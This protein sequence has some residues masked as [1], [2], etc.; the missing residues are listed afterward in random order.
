M[1]KR[2][3]LGAEGFRN[4]FY[5]G[6]TFGL[7]N[8]III[9]VLFWVVFNFVLNRTRFGRHVYAVGS[10]IDASRLSGVNITK[11][12]TM[13]YMVSSICSCTVGLAVSYTHLREAAAVAA[14]GL[15]LAVCPNVWGTVWSE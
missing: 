11:T 14:C 13:A 2:Q 9:A 6:K 3:G 15:F 4:F 12:I 7:Y 5:Y 8:T 10:N 1:Y